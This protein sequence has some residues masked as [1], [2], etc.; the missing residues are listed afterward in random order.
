MQIIRFFDPG[1]EGFVG[2]MAR[3]AAILAVLFACLIVVGLS[4]AMRSERGRF[5]VVAALSEAN[6][7]GLATPLAHDLRVDYPT[8]NWHY[9]RLEARNLRRMG[10]IAESLAVYDDAIAALPDEWWAHS[11][12]CFYSALLADAHRVMDSCNRQIELDPQ[13]PDIAYERRAVARMMVGDRAG[14]I[15]DLQVALDELRRQTRP[16]WR[17]PVRESWLHQL[18]AGENPLNEAAIREEL[19]HY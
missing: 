7:Y 2:R 4:L 12:R 9:Y 3:V 8:A 18:Q 5:A 10:R 17:L 14:A 1:Q 11:H 19:S 15:E 16:D 6:L 13:W